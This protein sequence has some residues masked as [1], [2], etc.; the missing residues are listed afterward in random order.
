MTP[1]GERE[2][3]RSTDRFQW[4]GRV[5]KV[6]PGDH[7]VVG[8]VPGTVALVIDCEDESGEEMLGYFPEAR[9]P[10]IGTRLGAR[11]HFVVIDVPHESIPPE[12]RE[13]LG[14]LE[15]C[16]VVQHQLEVTDWQ[17]VSED[18]DWLFD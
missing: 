13:L 1:S 18:Y 10:K 12:D 4:V 15:G 7:H 8:E 3:A 16:Q 17:V 5:R 2:E 11:G 9:R 14:P 6:R